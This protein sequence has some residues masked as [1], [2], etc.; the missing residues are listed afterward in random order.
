MTPEIREN[1]LEIATENAEELYDEHHS[2]GLW[3]ENDALPSDPNEF[4]RSE[5][6]EVFSAQR[7]EEVLDGQA[8]TE[9]ELKALRQAR[10]E[11]ISTGDSDA[12]N[13]PGYS[14]AEIADAE[15]NTGVAFIL[16]SGHSFSGLNIWVAEIFESKEAASAYLE[17]NGQTIFPI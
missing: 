1:L 15:G 11:S 2:G 9:D 16:C 10:L 4:S 13:I 8:V 7:L 14:L 17:K 3:V 5:L 12:G 6:E